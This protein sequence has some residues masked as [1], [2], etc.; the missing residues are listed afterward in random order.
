MVRWESSSVLRPSESAG[1]LG[2]GPARR[3]ITDTRIISWCAHDRPPRYTADRRSGTAGAA[4]PRRTIYIKH[5]AVVDCIM[6]PAL[7]P[8]SASAGRRSSRPVRQF[9]TGGGPTHQTSAAQRSDAHIK[10]P[11]AVI[12]RSPSRPASRNLLRNAPLKSAGR[13]T[14]LWAAKQGRL[15]DGNFLRTVLTAVA[16]CDPGAPPR[17]GRSALP[18]PCAVLT[19][20][21]GPPANP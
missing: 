13:K 17:S 8:P 3:S 2:A 12:N 4:S 20:R 14:K 21:R 15:S 10:D 9:P 1:K 18:L 5:G 6:R 19:P 7:T 16:L 11:S